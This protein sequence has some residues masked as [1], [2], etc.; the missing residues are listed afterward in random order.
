[1]HAVDDLS[2]AI[3]VT[4]DLLLPFRAGLW[5]KLAIVVL[6]VGGIGLGG[7]VPFDPGFVS[8]T[9]PITDTEQSPAADLDVDVGLILL[10]VGIVVGLWVL[11]SL[12]SAIM[13]FVFIESLRSGAVSIGA[14]AKTH[15]GSGLRLFGFRLGLQLVA[16]GLVG[17]PA[18]LT[19]TTAGTDVALGTVLVFGLWGIAVGL[20]YA[21]V[22]RF[23]SEFVAPV[24]VLESRGVLSSWRRFS[25]PLTA[26][27]AE[28]L[29]YLLLVW[30][31]QLVVNIAVG[32]MI[33]IFLVVLAIPVLIL[34]FAFFQ[35]G[36]TGVLLFVPVA[37]L[38]GVVALLGVATIQMPF[39][40]YFKYYALLLLGDTEES[41]DLIPDQRAETR[42]GE[43]ERTSETAH[44]DRELGAAVWDREDADPWGESVWESASDR[45]SDEDSQSAPTADETS[46]SDD[47]WTNASDWDRP[48]EDEDR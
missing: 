44:D 36:Q 47:E 3:D 24:M 20:A 13:E 37:I 23:T 19:Y 10:V 22:S 21:V 31:L 40:T 29:V 2:D 33:L 1:M 12:V 48:P 32:I 41:L 42:R 45:S 14:Y 25:G 11:F 38:A 4:R 26:R 35:L 15:A 16:S 8:E 5:V 28:F 27:W 30:I 46:A 18:Y 9:D 39:R 34:G 17:V 43:P 6:F 7:S